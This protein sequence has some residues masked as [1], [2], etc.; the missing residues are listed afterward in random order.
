[1]GRR[2][3]S[4]ETSSLA[5]GFRFH[6]T[7]EEL[8]RYYLKR[9]ICNKPFKFDA[10]SVTHVYKSEPWDLPSQSK[11]KSRDLEWYFFSVLDNKYSN[12]S[13][14]NRATEMG[15]WK[16]TGKDREIRNGS[17]VVGM[18]KTLV[19]HKGRAPRGERSNW[20]MHEYRLVDDEIVKAGV[21]KD[22]YVLCK[23]FQKSGSGPKNGE[24]YGAPFVEEEWEEE[25]GMTFEPNQDPGSLE[26]QVYVDIHD[27]DQ[28]LD[29]YDAIPIHL[30]FDQGESSNNVETNHSDTTNYIQPGNYVHDNFEGPVD[31][32]EE[33]QQLIIR[34]A[35][36]PDEENGCGVKDEITAN[37]QSCDNIFE[38]DASLYNDFPVEGNY[39]TGEEFLDPNDGLYLETNDLNST[40]KDGF[41]FEDYLTFFDEDDQNLTFDPSQLMG[42]GDVIPDQE[43]LFQMA[44]TKELEKEEAS[45]G[46]HVVEEK[47]NDEACCSKQVNA[48]T[49]EFEPDYKNSVLKK[50]SHMFGAIPT[51]TEFVSEILTKDGVVR[52][53]AGQSSGSVH[54]SMITVSDSNMGWSYSKNG[55]LCFGMVQENVPGKSENNLTR[56]MLIFICFWVLVLSVSF[57]ISTLV[58]SR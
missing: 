1:M 4:S 33:E 14:T 55:D 46:K 24:Q 20:V 27:I 47:E 38:T 6:P 2:G 52:L 42:T 40:E 36:F 17:R 19:Y 56:V 41:N 34:D 53:Q 26:D 48:D 5:P 57:K 7:D 31:L 11:L 28:K 45:G 10:I 9:K 43:E 35:L 23:I 32:S 3:G 39:F 12:G 15:Y 29:V 8:V 49:T 51:P 16:T 58:S 25:D 50:A 30:G 18:K 21:Q 44:E 54:V 37:L 13:K 22:A